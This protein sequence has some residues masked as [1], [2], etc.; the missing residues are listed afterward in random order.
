MHCAFHLSFPFSI[1]TS[2]VTAY[3]LHVTCLWLR[4]VCALLPIRSKPDANQMQTRSTT[5]PQQVH[6][7]IKTATSWTHLRTHLA[8]YHILYCTTVHLCVSVFPSVSPL[9]PHF[10][11][12]L[13]P[14]N[15]SRQ[16]AALLEPGSVRGFFP[17]KGSFSLPLSPSACS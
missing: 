8:F 17:L 9:H 1:P 12:S 2:P 7:L 16:M 4:S 14:P 5:G 3:C 13:C 11:L 6:T 10:P 15:R